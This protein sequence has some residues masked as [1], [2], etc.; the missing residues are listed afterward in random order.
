MLSLLDAAISCKH[1]LQGNLHNI[2][3]IFGG[4]Q[5]LPDFEDP[6]PAEPTWI[7]DLF[8]T[9]SMNYDGELI[10]KGIGSPSSSCSSSS[11]S[12]V[13]FPPLPSLSPFFLLPLLSLLLFF[14][15]PPSH[16][17]SSSSM[18]MSGSCLSCN[19]VICTSISFL[20]I[21]T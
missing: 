5:D 15:L 20:K 3:Q 6:N 7:Q 12:S 16:F 9:F 8:L 19:C 18:C 14:P 1:I 17:S 4:L 13:S 21:E 2:S 11:S 10:R